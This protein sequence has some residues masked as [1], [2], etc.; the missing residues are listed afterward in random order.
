MQ[1]FVA[2]KDPTSTMRSATGWVCKRYRVD[3]SSRTHQRLFKR[4]YIVVRDWGFARE[5]ALGLQP[6]PQRCNDVDRNNETIESIFIEVYDFV[7]S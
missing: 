2:L 4:D 1:F 5:Y 3:L 6:R 7:F